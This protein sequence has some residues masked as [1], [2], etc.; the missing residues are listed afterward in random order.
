MTHR[1]LCPTEQSFATDDLPLNLSPA[2]LKQRIA[3]MVRVAV[4]QGA[5]PVAANVVRYLWALYL[6]PELVA[7]RQ[8][9]TA[10]RRVANH[11][12]GLAAIVG[13]A[14]G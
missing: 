8:E 9:R 14:R 10:Y 11:W 13:D 12:R 7:D 4:H 1:T 5:A 2:S 6:H 3:E